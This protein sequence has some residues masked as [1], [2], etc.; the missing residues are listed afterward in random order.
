MSCCQ[1]LWLFRS[2]RLDI[3]WLLP[4]T[5]TVPAGFAAL[6]NVST[7]YHPELLKHTVAPLIRT[8]HWAITNLFGKPFKKR[9]L[10]C[11]GPDRNHFW[12]AS[13]RLKVFTNLKHPFNH[14][15]FMWSV[16]NWFC[17]C[18]YMMS[19]GSLCP[20]NSNRFVSDLQL[21]NWP[22][23]T[24]SIRMKDVLHFLNL[25][26]SRTFVLDKH[27]INVSLLWPTGSQ[28]SCT[29]RL[30]NMLLIGEHFKPSWKPK[31]R[32]WKSERY[33]FEILWRRKCFPLCARNPSVC[34]EAGSTR[35]NL[36]SQSAHLLF[37]RYSV[38]VRS[39][40]LSESVE[41]VWL[42]D[43]MIDADLI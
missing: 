24:P 29:L 26:L 43:R 37:N 39:A 38:L 5:V 17:D 34:R 9:K 25:F 41:R 35:I 13:D 11:S 20:F 2:A 10:L 42:Y 32:H 1:N 19:N 15:P 3:H 8:T 22:N 18:S 36:W 4:S 33:A 6:F 14:H 27:N 30:C 7:D 23:A 31:T 21:A 40:G 12:D 16:V 28:D